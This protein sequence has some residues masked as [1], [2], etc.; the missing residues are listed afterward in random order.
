M[1]T[2]DRSRLHS[3]RV[4]LLATSMLVI[5]A[6]LLAFG[7]VAD[8]L[9]RHALL[10]NIENDLKRRGAHFASSVLPPDGRGPGNSSSPR[11][12]NDKGP[13]FDGPPPDDGG[14]F[15]SD[16]PPNGG[17]PSKNSSSG[18]SG[19]PDQMLTS[20]SK[21]NEEWAAP[22]NFAVASFEEHKNDVY[23]PIGFEMA[24]KGKPGFTTVL[25][26][27]EP[28]RVYS[29]PTYR[30]GK[31]NE[32]VQVAAPIGSALAALQNLRWLLI[33]VG[34]PVGILLGGLATLVLVSKFLQPLG[35]LNQDAVR[36]EGMGFGER[37][38]VLGRD[39][40][41]S[42]A[43]TLN[44]MLGR[45]ESLYRQQTDTADALRR[46]VEQQRRFTADASHELK[47]PLTIVKAN[48]GIMLGDNL[49]DDHRTLVSDIDFAADQ[50]TSIVRDL[51]LLAR[52]D[53]GKLNEAPATFDLCEAVTEAIR[54]VPNAKDR[55]ELSVPQSP[56]FANGQAEQIGRVVINL[57]GNALVHSESKTPIE[58]FVREDRETVVI[59]V[60]DRGKGIAAS[61]LPHLFER[62]YR[63]DE[64]R[65]SETGGSGLGLA[66]CEAIVRAHHGAIG[67]ESEVG[68]GTRI[69]VTLPK[70]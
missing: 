66:I 31:I 9:F 53:A 20:H 61:H 41:A 12:S 36:I 10:S 67:V 49:S 69:K 17:P 47:T 54:S 11:Q 39:E 46:T 28:V 60:V 44:R 65:S 29:A 33:V 24:A 19:P 38:A 25:R 57:V 58:V 50:M 48:T 7:I 26:N 35:Q 14:P 16:G 22:I 70:G 52:A 23:D 5:M 30:Q 56:I 64:S 45:L 68:R 6:L 8:Q 42:L 59:E 4:R 40:F 51:L 55:V 15:A 37:L 63:I 1:M 43:E 34:I 62:F 21:S 18:N 2:S 3:V 13:S 32:V 27:G